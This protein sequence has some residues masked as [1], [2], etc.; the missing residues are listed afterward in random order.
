MKTREDVVRELHDMECGCE[1]SAACMVGAL[2]RRAFDAGVA[3][4]RAL[5]NRNLDTALRLLR[6]FYIAYFKPEWQEGECAEEMT[7]SVRL[8]LDAAARNGFHVARVERG[9][10]TREESGDPDAGRGMP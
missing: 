2:A 4:E 9:S 6:D 8:F 1:L 7:V 10:H 3:H 5:L